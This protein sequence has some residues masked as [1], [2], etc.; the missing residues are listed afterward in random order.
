MSTL[1]QTVF[2]SFV[3]VLFLVAAFCLASEALRAARS[4][5]RQSLAV[6]DSEPG[7]DYPDDDWA[8]S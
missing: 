1:Q 2:W 7:D 8:A 3:V 6:L 5:L 4:Q